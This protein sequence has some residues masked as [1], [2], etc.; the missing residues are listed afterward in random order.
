MIDR[1]TAPEEDAHDLKSQQRQT[2]HDWKQ[3]DVLRI[4]KGDG[5]EAKGGDVERAVQAIVEGA[6]DEVG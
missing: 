4:W 6:F 2:I 1:R 3:E 5:L